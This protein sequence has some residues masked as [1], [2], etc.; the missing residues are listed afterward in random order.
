MLPIGGSGSH[1]TSLC[2]PSPLARRI[3][4]GVDDHQLGLARCVRRRRVEVQIAE[5]P[6]ESEVLVLG[7]MLVA[8]ENHQILGKRAMDLVEGAVAERLREIDPADLTADDRRQLV[9][10]YRVV[11]RRHVGDMLVTRPVVRTDGIHCAFLWLPRVPYHIWA[12]SIATLRAIRSAISSSPNPVSRRISRE[13]CP[14]RGAGWRNA[15]SASLNR[16]GGLTIRMLP[17]VGCS[18]G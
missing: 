16:T 5:Q 12:A 15:Q 1:D 10:R 13:C 6:A 3:L 2:Q 8:E 11:R 18:A 4:V 7:Q 17:S 9:D 14:N